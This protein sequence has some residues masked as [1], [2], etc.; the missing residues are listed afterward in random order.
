MARQLL[1]ACS[2]QQEPG[3][4]QIMNVGPGKPQTLRAFAEFCWEKWNG[5]AKLLFGV[6]PYR[7][8]EVMRYV[9]QLK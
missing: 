8:G 6:K 4:P 3:L 9:P 1:E 7:D 5:K 2:A